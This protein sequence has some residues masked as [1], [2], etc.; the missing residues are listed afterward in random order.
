MINPNELYTTDFL[1]ILDNYI[2]AVITN[3][4]LGKGYLLEDINLQTEPPEVYIQHPEVYFYID[5][6]I[7]ESNID[8]H[9][10]L[11]CDGNELKENEEREI[12]ELTKTLNKFHIWFN[13]IVTNK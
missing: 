4:Y 8:L 6:R 7:E 13:E 2:I 11:A 9:C 1:C 3:F 12:A 5:I 10:C